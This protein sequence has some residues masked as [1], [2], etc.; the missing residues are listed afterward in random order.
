ML[1][2]LPFF[3]LGDGLLGGDRAER[4]AAVQ[5]VHLEVLQH[6]AGPAGG[7]KVSQIPYTRVACTTKN[8][9]STIFDVENRFHKITFSI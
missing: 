4:V 7:A 5:A 2:S 6:H 8:I 3:Y 9:Y 1:V